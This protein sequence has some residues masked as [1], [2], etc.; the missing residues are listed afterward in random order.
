[1][2][3]LELII[4]PMFSGKSSEIIRRI[5]LYEVINKKILAINYVND[6]RYD[7]NK[8]VS[9]NKE[10]NKCVM[11]DDLTILPDENIILYDII[12]VD[13]GQFFKNLKECVLHWVDNLKLHVI[14]S[15]LDG[16][17]KRNPIGEILSLIPYADKYK[18]MTALCKYCSDETPGIFTHRLCKN[19]TQIIIGN[20]DIYVSLCRNHYLELNK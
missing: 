13:E 11:L 9:H 2:G 1:M 20:D 18:K 5:R 3:K 4:G 17:F 7:E 6:T 8:I 15:G 14:V 16:D 19:D 12:I 10:S